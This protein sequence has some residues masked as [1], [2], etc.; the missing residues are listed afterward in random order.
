MGVAGQVGENRLG[1]GERALGIDNPFALTQRREPVG[2]GG[3]VGQLGVLAE[4]LPLAAAMR[5]LQ[6]FEEAAPKQA[7]E[8]AYRQEEPRLAGNPTIRIER[9]ATTGHDAVH[10]RM[11]RQCRAQVCRTRVTPIGAPR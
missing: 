11:M 9:Q 8:H 2:E 7:R 10:M 6:F 4:E 1:S 5:V 3:G